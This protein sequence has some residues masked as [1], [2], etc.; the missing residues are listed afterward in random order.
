MQVTIPYKPLDHQVAMHYDNE[1]FRFIVGGRRAGKSVSCFQEALRY[2]LAGQNLVVWWVAPTYSEAREIGY[3]Q[4]LDFFDVLR[5][6]I[7][8]VHH[9]QMRVEFTNGSIF[10]FKGA[11]RKDSLRGRGLD[12]LVVDEAAFIPEDVWRKVLRPALSDKQGRAILISTPNGKNWFYDQYQ[13]AKGLVNWTTFFWPSYV[14]KFMSK[15]EIE[16]AKD[17]LSDADF[18]QEYMA[19]FLTR[20]GQVYDDFSELNIIDS[21]SPDPSQHDFYIGVDFG[22]ANPTA[23]C[24][25][26]VDKQTEVVTQFDELYKERMTMDQMQVLIQDILSKHNLNTNHIKAVF[27]DPAGNAE[28]ITSGIAPVDHLRKT[29]TVINK[30]T[31][32]APGLS[33]VRSFI[34]N[35]HGRRRFFITKDCLNTK[36]SF[37]GYTY[38]HKQTSDEINEE[39]FKDGLHDHMCD[40]V[41]YFFVNR[42]D[43]AKYVADK[44]EHYSYFHKPSA[45]VIMKRCSVCRIPF[46]SKTPKNQ[47]PFKCKECSNNE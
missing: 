27:T 22:Y 45:S 28:E 17:E 9:S 11:D 13:T 37:E 5:P 24:F 1:R 14:N 4:F 42:F 21:F 40:A 38:K 32:I 8:N 23:A 10:Y 35:A 47:P 16:A 30:G 3:Q 43:H 41:R 7:K 44:V 31:R 6:A 20:A 25:M 15:E 33:L 36:R 46:A 26:A 34:K 2:C 18:R 29:F 39:P 19:E 12:F